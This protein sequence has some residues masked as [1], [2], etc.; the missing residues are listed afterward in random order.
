MDQGE[1]LPDAASCE[2]REAKC[3]IRGGEKCL[4]A[5]VDFCPKCSEDIHTRANEVRKSAWG[6]FVT[7]GS[8]AEV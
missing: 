3:I 2:F 5:K 8:C 7:T 1:D 4:L 6:E